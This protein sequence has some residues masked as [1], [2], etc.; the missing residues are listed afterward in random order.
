LSCGAIWSERLFLVACV[1]YVLLL[2]LSFQ[3]FTCSINVYLELG[4]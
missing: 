2:A 1:L 4:T 3:Q